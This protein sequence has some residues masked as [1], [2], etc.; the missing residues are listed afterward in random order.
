MSNLRSLETADPNIL[1]RRVQRKNLPKVGTVT[2][3]RTAAAAAAEADAVT[4]EEMDEARDG[5]AVRSR[6]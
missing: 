3:E 5:I 2:A 1:R 4:D 6:A